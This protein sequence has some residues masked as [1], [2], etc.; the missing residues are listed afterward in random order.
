MGCPF[1]PSQNYFFPSCWKWLR[2]KFRS[3]FCLTSQCTA[4]LDA[5]LGCI[6]EA[7]VTMNTHKKIVTFNK[8]AECIFG[9]TREEA[10]GKNINILMPEPC[11]SEHDEYVDHY[12]KTGERKVIGIGR[13][14]EGKRKNGSIFSLYLCVHEISE[15]KDRYFIGIMRDLTLEK[16][17]EQLKENAIRIN[18]RMDARNEYITILSHELRT[19]LA[20]VHGSIG[21]LLTEEMSSDKAKELLRI[22][23]RNTERLRVVI[24]D[25]LDANKIQS[26]YLKIE[27]QPLSL[28]PLIKD[29]ITSW[30]PLAKTK[31][32]SIIEDFSVQ[33]VW[34]VANYDR[35]IQVCLNFLSNAVKFSFGQTEVKVSVSVLADKVRVSVQDQGIGIPI[36]FY[37]QVFTPFSQVTSEYNKPEGIGLSLYICKKIIENFNGTID[38]QSEEGKGSLFFFELPLYKGTK[39]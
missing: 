13:Q 8:A 10:I 1:Q 3:Y 20:S 23:Y 12:F 11:H 21:L 36:S 31:N 26:G 2:D 14:V 39:Q 34:V 33:E 37:S 9:Y 7:V 6:S 35:L 24:Q 4:N 18:A 19:P 5:V 17:N 30:L 29:A 38:F 28:L 22:A 27:C 25:V 16:E 15:G 32:I